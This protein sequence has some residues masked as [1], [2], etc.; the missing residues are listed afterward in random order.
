MDM[1]KEETKTA[2]VDNRMTALIRQAVVDYVNSLPPAAKE[3]TSAYL[4]EVLNRTV[5]L[6]AG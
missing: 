3:A 6:A 4:S 2:Q 1:V 5:V